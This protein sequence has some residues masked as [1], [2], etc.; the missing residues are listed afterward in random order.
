MLSKTN[1]IKH[2]NLNLLGRLFATIIIPVSYLVGSFFFW[3]NMIP[4]DN[5]PIMGAVIITLFLVPTGLFILSAISFLFYR[6]GAYILYGSD[7]RNHE[8]LDIVDY[9]G[10]IIVGNIEYCFLWAF[11]DWRKEYKEAVK[12]QKQR[13]LEQD[14]DYRAAM[15]HLDEVLTKE[16]DY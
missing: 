4:S 3:K 5:E 12:A 7:K 8:R 16:G 10:E 13:E 11:G 6:L 2:S 14:P 9:I 15:K 1:Y